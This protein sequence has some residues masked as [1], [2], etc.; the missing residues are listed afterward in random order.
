MSDSRINEKR[1]LMVLDGMVGFLIATVV[2]V[3]VVLT[4]AYFSKIVQDENS[5]IFYDLKDETEI[6]S[7]IMGK[8]P[9]NPADHMIVVEETK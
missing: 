4:L 9:S 8:N 6:R 1:G 7:G 5:K 2:L 3:V